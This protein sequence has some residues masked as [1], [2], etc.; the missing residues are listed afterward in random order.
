MNRREL[1]QW[2]AFTGAVS[3]APRWVLAAGR[4]ASN[5]RHLISIFLRG[6]ADGLTICAPLGDARYFDARRTLALDE[7]TALPLDGFFGMHPAAGG[8]KALFDDGELAIVHA[9]GL[10][11]AQRSHFQAQTAM[12]LGI[13]AFDL[14]PADGW[15]GR[16]LAGI[17]PD[18][19]LTAVAL[20]KAVPRAMAGIDHAL[21]L[22]A[23]DDF[24]LQLD[25]RAQ[26][27]LGQAYAADPL[28]A[29]TAEAALNAADALLPIS[30]MAPGEGYPQGPLGTALADAARLI[31][32]ESGLVA[33][34]INSGGWDHHDNQAQQIEPLLAQLGDALAA[35]RADL[36][37]K[38]ADTT[39][40]IQTEFGRRLRENASA[41][42]DHG[43]GGVMLAAGGGVNGGTIYADWPGLAPQDLSAGE[44]LAVTTDYRQVL[45]EMLARQFGAVDLTDIFPGWTPGPWQGIFD[46]TAAN[47]DRTVDRNRPVP[48]PKPQTFATRNTGMGAFEVPAIPPGLFP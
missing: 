41:G 28:L 18:S 26:T 42:T 35:F 31:L 10:A 44:D 38:W 11:S 4:Q 39:V 46:S 47:H 5:G 13:D 36:G 23:I 21:A 6:A 8:L 40:I 34:A 19:P 33:A 22:G 20:D 27:A 9:A 48:A 30:D 2:M 43:H 45:A 29:P 32:G 24:S 3:A 17:A 16:Y 14:A 12:E 15:L 1:L 25:P 7:T 37:A